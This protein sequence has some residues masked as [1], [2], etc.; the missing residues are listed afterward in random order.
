LKNTKKGG[1]LL[2]G[3]EGDF[4]FK[5][6]AKTPKKK[7]KNKTQT[8]SAALK[9]KKMWGNWRDYTRKERRVLALLFVI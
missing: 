4:L 5:P 3:G 6:P 9:G 2:W 1:V 8:P 7:K